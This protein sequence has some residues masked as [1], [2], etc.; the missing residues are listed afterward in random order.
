MKYLKLTICIMV[1]MVSGCGKQKITSEEENSSS[2]NLPTIVA[3]CQVVSFM[4]G[5][6]HSNSI[7]IEVY[8]IKGIVLDEFEYG[9]NIKLI[10]DLK[11]NFPKNINTF[12]VWGSNTPFNSILNRVDDLI[13]YDKD[14]TLIMLLT[15]TQD[16][17]HMHMEQPDEMKQIWLEIYE[18]YAILPC[19]FSCLK[20]SDN[21]V[22]GNIFPKN[23]I[24]S[25]PYNDI[26]EDIMLY[27]D[28]QKELNK[29][30]IK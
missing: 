13:W 30:L 15:P 16:L 20:L 6:L 17:S 24:Y 22:S 27:E 14:D 9:L 4:Q 11:G 28:F 2:E 5:V 7:E 12:R 25:T 21:Y 1:F 26:N 19:T 8:I 3:D 29:L 10:E 23:G 18:D